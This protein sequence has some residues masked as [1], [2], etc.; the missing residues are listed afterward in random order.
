MQSQDSRILV[1]EYDVM[2][3][4]NSSVYIHVLYSYYVNTEI[5]LTA[6]FFENKFVYEQAY[7]F[8]NYSSTL[9]RYP[10]ISGDKGC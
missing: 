5:M 7:M 6:T 1:T 2:V 8:T 4:Q 10:S 3:L 9:Q